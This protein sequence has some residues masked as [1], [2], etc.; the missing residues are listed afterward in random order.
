MVINIQLSS[1]DSLVII[2]D[3]GV[4]AQILSNLLIN[5]LV[6]AYEEK[7]EGTINID[8]SHAEQLADTP[9]QVVIHYTDDGVGMDEETARRAFDP[10]FTT[11][12]TS[13][14]SG[15]GLHIVYNLVTQSLKGKITLDTTPGTGARFTIIIPTE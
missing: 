10:F 13:G 6:H 11:R 3:P 8:I 15:L 1:D 7:Q 14:G 12:R 4:Y 5:S 2:A 9:A